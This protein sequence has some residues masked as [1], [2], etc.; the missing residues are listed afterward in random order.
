MRGYD[1]RNNFELGVCTKAQIVK[2]IGIVSCQSKVVNPESL[3]HLTM[4]GTSGRQR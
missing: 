1:I 4:L 2:G 3:L